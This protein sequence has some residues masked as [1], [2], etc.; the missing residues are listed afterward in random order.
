MI[1]R[2]VTGLQP[3]V[4]VKDGRARL[5]LADNRAESDRPR[6]R[7]DGRLE[8]D[9]RNTQVSP[10][11]ID[12]GSALEEY[13]RRLRMELEVVEAEVR[14]LNRQPVGAASAPGK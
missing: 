4:R 7:R 3:F 14:R 11:V 5:C 13:A 9:M 6:P 1:G 10:G 12:G 2:F 8:D